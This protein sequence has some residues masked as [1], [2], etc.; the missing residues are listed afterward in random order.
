MVQI[1]SYVIRNAYHTMN[2]L[3][4]FNKEQNINFLMLCD[5]TNR[6]RCK[7]KI[8]TTEELFKPKRQKFMGQEYHTERCSVIDWQHLAI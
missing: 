2:S 3:I 8:K 1:I 5:L 6:H 4:T 7:L